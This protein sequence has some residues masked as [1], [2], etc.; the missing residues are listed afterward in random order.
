MQTVGCKHVTGLRL[1][2][3]PSPWIH[4]KASYTLIVKLTRMRKNVGEMRETISVQMAFRKPSCQSFSHLAFCCSR[5]TVGIFTKRQRGDRE[6]FSSS[7][8]QNQRWTKSVI[9]WEVYSDWFA[10]S[11]NSART[12]R[13]AR[14]DKCI[15]SLRL[16]EIPYHDSIVHFTSHDSLKGL[17]HAEY[18]TNTESN[19]V[20][21]H[22]VPYYSVL[23]C[24]NRLL[25]SLAILPLLSR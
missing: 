9:L 16:M 2:G 12:C 6:S 20:N 15:A 13:N 23:I 1:V 10:I 7:F 21:V 19:T 3:I 8:S 25:W 5:Q 11:Q 4:S 22:T 17:T 18:L 14:N 24:S